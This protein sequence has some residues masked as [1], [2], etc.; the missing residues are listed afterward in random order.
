MLVNAHADM[1]RKKDK[2]KENV[3]PTKG[4]KSHP[5]SPSL[6]VFD[7]NSSVSGVTG[8]A[9]STPFSSKATTASLAPQYRAILTG[10]HFRTGPPAT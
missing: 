8:P 1:K 2:G 7:T 6:A 5:P 10:V 4:H 9:P 3:R